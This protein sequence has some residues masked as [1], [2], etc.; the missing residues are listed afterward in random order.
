MCTYVVRGIAGRAHQVDDSGAGPLGN[1][2][3][4]MLEHQ[5]LFFRGAIDEGDVFAWQVDHLEKRTHRRDS[6]AASDQQHPWPA[7]SPA[8]DDA[9]RAFGEDQGA[10]RNRK[11]PSRPIAARLDGDPQPMAGR[12]RGKGKGV[13]RAPGLARK[14]P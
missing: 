10:T 3:E 13:R 4:L 5:I 14:K 7:A 12:W 6:N 9:V 1:L 11:K 2:I 8:G